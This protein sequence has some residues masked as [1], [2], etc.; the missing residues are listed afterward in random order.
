MAGKGTIAHSVGD[1]GKNDTRDVLIVQML[2]ENSLKLFITDWP[3][4]TCGKSTIEGI[5]KFQKNVVK[6]KK[7]DGLVSPGGITIKAL[8]FEK[9]PL[10]GYGWYAY[11]AG[12]DRKRWGSHDTIESIRLLARKVKGKMGVE[13]GVSDIS[14]RTGRKLPPH[15]GHRKGVEVDIRPIR[16]DGAQKACHIS[17]VAIYDQERTKKL[18]KLILEDQNTKKILFNDTDIEGVAW[19]TGHH[20]HLHVIYSI[21]S[22]PYS[23]VERSIEMLAGRVQR[24]L[25]DTI[26]F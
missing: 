1:G 2:L 16:K 3:P 21:A 26:G 12:L 22:H 13:I 5:K 8:T 4:G 23:T 7:P 14:R 25:A 9:L 6:L 24:G 10:A 18:V 19:A 11:G 15:K 20:H 17:W